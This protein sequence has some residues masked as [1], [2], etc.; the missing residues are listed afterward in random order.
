MKDNSMD[1]QSVCQSMRNFD[2]FSYLFELNN[3][4]KGFNGN[5]N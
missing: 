5:V 3:T 1:C 4:I 2:G